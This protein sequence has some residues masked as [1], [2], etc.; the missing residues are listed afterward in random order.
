MRKRPVFPAGKESGAQVLE[1][2]S[3]YPKAPDGDVGGP[4]ER[5]VVQRGNATSPRWAAIRLLREARASAQR[6]A[7][8]QQTSES[9]EGRLLFLSHHRLQRSKLLSCFF[10]AL[11]YPKPSGFPF[12]FFFFNLQEEQVLT[13]GISLADSFVSDA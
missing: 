12:P 4:M 9:V 13:D 5:W 1:W 2:W 11:F 6:E 10:K 3:L 7:D 8:V